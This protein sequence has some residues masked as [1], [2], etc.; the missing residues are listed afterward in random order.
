MPRIFDNIDQQFL[1]ALRDTF[2]ISDRAQE[3]RGDD[4]SQIIC[5]PALRGDVP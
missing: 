4:L 5:S 3:D 2:T 1:S